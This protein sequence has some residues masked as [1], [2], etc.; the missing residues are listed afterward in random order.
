MIDLELSRRWHPTFDTLEARIIP[1]VVQYIQTVT[2][3]DTGQQ[4]TVTFNW[5]LASYQSQMLLQSEAQLY[6]STSAM[7]ADATNALNSIDSDGCVDGGKLTAL[8]NDTDATYSIAGQYMNG[9]LSSALGLNDD[10]SNPPPAQID[11]SVV[12][13]PT[14]KA[15]VKVL[16]QNAQLLTTDTQAWV[17]SMNAAWKNGNVLDQ[18]G[19]TVVAH[20]HVQQN[21]KQMKLITAECNAIAAKYPGVIVPGS[22]NQGVPQ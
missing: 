14:A 1:S 3:V 11:S 22:Q 5:D 6:T 15:R 2:N 18:V 21:L 10:Y 19:L 9:V 17:N 8:S 4:D 12:D 16:L 13:L 20:S 7:T